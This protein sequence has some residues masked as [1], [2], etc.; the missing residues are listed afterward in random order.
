MTK[1]PDREGH[2]APDREPEKRDETAWDRTPEAVDDAEVVEIIDPTGE[3]ERAIDVSAP[4]PVADSGE[5]I[6]I[7][8]DLRELRQEIHAG[9]P[10]LTREHF[11]AEVKGNSAN[12]W[13]I[14]RVD[15]SPEEKHELALSLAKRMPE[16]LRTAPRYLTDLLTPDERLELAEKELAKVD[17]KTRLPNLTY[18]Y[19]L[20][21]DQVERIVSGLPKDDQQE[22]I[23]SLLGPDSE[24]TKY[25]GGMN[26][27]RELAESPE[28]KE[29]ARQRE[30]LLRVLAAAERELPELAASIR[31]HI[32]TVERLAD[33]KIVKGRALGG[34]V[35]APLQVSLEGLNFTGVLKKEIR[36][37]ENQSQ[38]MICYQRGVKL[39][40]M[41]R[42]ELYGY[43]VGVL[44]DADVAPTAPALDPDG[45]RSTLHVYRTNLR[46][47]KRY[48]HNPESDE[49]EMLPVAKMTRDDPQFRDRVELTAVHGDV[50]ESND[51][52]PANAPIYSLGN[53]ENGINPLDF[54]LINGSTEMTGLGGKGSFL[55][56]TLHVLERERHDRGEP[57]RLHEVKVRVGL[58]ARERRNFVRLGAAAQERVDRLLAA[59][60]TLTE[61]QSWLSETYDEKP[62]RKNSRFAK[63][64]RNLKQAS[65]HGIEQNHPRWSAVYKN[66][67][68][69]IPDPPKESQA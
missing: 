8:V 61:L 58:L 1:I 42:N 6:D 29:I 2:H 51:S 35:T 48:R 10:P 11:L 9:E 37:G 24:D 14:D 40:D 26:F 18:I 33:A 12:A 52:R 36:L 54:G 65:A 53:G 43:L 41:P 62:R 21:T 34:G 17:P 13:Q 69:D 20:S 39:E 46:I 7:D 25:Y 57:T 27:E 50:L 59:E 66:V 16:A 4:T 31:R 23:S 38:D 49:P 15:I 68:R 63:L 60:E 67:A 19:D 30:G 45:R 55:T 44:L 56:E 5:D 64:V 47:C 32:E 22:V 3:T 28:A